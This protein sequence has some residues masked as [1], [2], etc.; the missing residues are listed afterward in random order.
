MVFH[1]R[2]DDGQTLNAGLV[3]LLF[4]RGGGGGGM[5]PLSPL[6]IRAWNFQITLHF[7][8]WKLLYCK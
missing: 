8:H 5:D 4:S 2:A 3:A 7:F 6:W 1:W